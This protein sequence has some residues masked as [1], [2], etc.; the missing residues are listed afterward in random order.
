MLNS[1]EIQGPGIEL[2]SG[3]GAFREN[4]GHVR[5]FVGC[6]EMFGNV[7]LARGRGE[8][9]SNMPE[10]G[11]FWLVFGCV[12]TVS[13]RVFFVRPPEG[14]GSRGEGS[15]VSR[16]GVGPC[17]DSVL[18]SPACL[19]AYAQ[20]GSLHG[21]GFVEC[22]LR[23]CELRCWLVWEGTTMTVVVMMGTV[24]RWSS[25]CTSRGE[26]PTRTASDDRARFFS[27]RGRECG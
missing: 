3:S 1:E 2:G 14:V 26:P 4:L 24:T 8:R 17:G 15:R 21:R 27:C 10:I 23:M 7:I 11:D 20:S 5:V 9:V 12:G 25:C 6:L 19:Q 16:R 13:S 18:C 22:R